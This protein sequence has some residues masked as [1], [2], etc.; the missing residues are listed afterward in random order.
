[1]NSTVHQRDRRAPGAASVTRRHQPRVP[2]PDA[3]K[4]TWKAV[5]PTAEGLRPMKPSSALAKS[6]KRS[7]RAVSA[8][9]A[10]QK[11]ATH[12]TACL[13]VAGCRR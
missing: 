7:A 6:T 10:S 8:S 2:L 11:A 5:A 3:T 12:R 13:G 1:M 4:A 9:P